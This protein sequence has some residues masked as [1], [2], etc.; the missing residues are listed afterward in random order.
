MKPN[1]MFSVMGALAVIASGMPP[2]PR[3]RYRAVTD[4]PVPYIEERVYETI[5]I[6]RGARAQIS[7]AERENR[8]AARR[9]RMQARKR[10]GRR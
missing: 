4:A 1:A 6:S 2:P 5:E 10:T 3:G 9:S 7:P 8:K